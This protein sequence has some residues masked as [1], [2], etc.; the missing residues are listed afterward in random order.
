MILEGVLVLWAAA[1]SVWA[2]FLGQGFFI[3]VA[4]VATVWGIARVVKGVRYRRDP[5]KLIRDLQFV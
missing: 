3:I 4:M 1:T 5:V 2:A